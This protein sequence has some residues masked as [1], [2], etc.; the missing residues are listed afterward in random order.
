MKISQKTIRDSLVIGLALFSMFFG[1]GNLIFPPK[2]GLECGDRW[3]TGFLFYFMIDI[4]LGIL[5]VFSMIRKNGDT[6]QI[7][8]PIGRIPSVAVMTLIILCIGP[9]IALPRTAATTYEIGI[10]PIAQTDS[11]PITLAI[12]SVAFFAAVLLLS[13]HPGRVVDII[14][15][16]LTPVLLASLLLLIIRGIAAPLDTMGQPLTESPVVDGVLNGYQT[17]DMLAAILFTVIL[18]SSVRGKGYQTANDSRPVLFASS[19][20]AGALLFIVYGGLTYLGATSGAPWAAEAHSEQLSNAALLVNITEGLLGRFGAVLLAIVVTFACLTTAISL[21]AA[22]AEYFEDLFSGHISYRTLVIMVCLIS[23][24]ICNL[25]L[26]RIISIAAPVLMLLY[27]L[28]VVLILTSFLHDLVPGRLPYVFAAGAAFL[29]SIL[30][31]INEL[32]PDSAA[33]AIDTALPLSRFDFEWLLPAAAAFLAGLAISRARAGSCLPDA[34]E[35]S[36][37]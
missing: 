36:E 11:D 17:L 34:D 33:A 28:M 10:L 16:F 12:F 25:G 6:H 18:I 14:G 29:V 2:L 26:T 30:S 8:D 1:A 35:S 23:C 27:P 15:K 21:V 5:A 13:I 24:L 31:S 3:G 37:Y 32:F 22:A 4:G 20:L 19:L 9:G 7:L